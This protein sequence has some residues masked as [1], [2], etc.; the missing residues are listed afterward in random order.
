[1]SRQVKLKGAGDVLKTLQK[2]S[3]RTEKT[4]PETVEQAAFEIERDASL[5]VRVDKGRLKGSIQ[6]IKQ[7]DT[8]FEVSAGGMEVDG[9]EVDYAGVI[10]FGGKNRAAYPF[11]RPAADKARARYADTV[12]SGVEKGIKQAGV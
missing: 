1:M 2:I 3:A 7:D 9:K 4:I 6:T 11:M 5:T 12:I 8:H 10:E